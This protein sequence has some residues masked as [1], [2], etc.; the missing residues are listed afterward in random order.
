MPYSAAPVPKVEC[1]IEFCYIH[2]FSK[3]NYDPLEIVIRPGANVT[4]IIH[5]VEPFTITSGNG[6][7]DLNSGKLFDSGVVMLPFNSTFSA[8]FKE[9]G[10]FSF[11]SKFN[12]ELVG[13]I[14]VKGEPFLTK[15]PAKIEISRPQEQIRDVQIGSKPDQIIPTMTSPYIVQYALPDSKSAPVAIAAD[16]KDNI[17]FVEWNASKLAVL[18]PSNNTLKEFRIPVSK[19]PLQ[20]WSIVIDKVHVWFGEAQSNS[21]WRFSPNNQTF[22]QYIV[23]TQY[24]GVVQLAIAK[25]GNLW[26]TELYENKIAKLSTKELS[27]G[28]S[29]GIVEYTL[30]TSNSG[31][32]GLAIDKDGKIWITQ[33]FAKKLARFD[34]ET[35]TFDIFEF[36]TTV[37]SPLG[38]V[39]DQ[40]G[41]WVASHGSNKIVKFDPSSGSIKQYSTSQATSSPI[42]LPY[43]VMIDRQSNI[44]FNEHAGGKIARFSPESETMVEYVVP[45]ALNS[46][47]YMTLDSSGNAWF[48]ES[49]AGKIGKIDASIKPWFEVSISGKTVHSNGE[50]V[51]VGITVYS[52]NSQKRELVLVLMNAQ[53]ISGRLENMTSSFQAG[54]ISKQGV[55]LESLLVLSPSMHARQGNYAFTISVTDGSIVSSAIFTLTLAQ[56]SKEPAPKAHV[57]ESQNNLQSKE[58]ER[59]LPS[60]IQPSQSN[61][62]T[63][64]VSNPLLIITPAIILCGAALYYI[65]RKGKRS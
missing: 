52:E 4:W 34:P 59:E 6:P 17:W 1:Q 10:E 53:S 31:P 3:T 64:S 61:V 5:V 11:Y 43:W 29:Q 19:V 30:P 62:Q 23:P 51:S 2:I 39:A 36:P 15:E 65:K 49:I 63:V 44:W 8:R 7:N 9:S 55:V 35:L 54:K 20:V 48:T 16:D 14:T 25:S 12:P 21:V 27:A 33:T 58:P 22:Q 56:L 40:S 46:I 24:A 28:T 37:Y 47:L 32:A 41:V 60:R 13:K 26:L 38:I 57:I 42:S 45:N 50:D 18:F